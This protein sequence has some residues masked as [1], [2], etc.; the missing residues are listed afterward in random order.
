MKEIVLFV[1]PCAGPVAADPLDSRR[2]FAQKTVAAAV[3][4]LASRLFTPDN[5]AEIAG[6][7]SVPRLPVANPCL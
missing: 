6:T 7:M 1:A 3:I 4:D 2:L 5:R